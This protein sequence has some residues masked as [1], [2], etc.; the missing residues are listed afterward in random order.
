M[1]EKDLDTRLKECEEKL[2]R[3]DQM[4]SIGKVVWRLFL[5][6]GAAIVAVTEV[7]DRVQHSWGWWK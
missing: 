3:L 2:R 6:T 1:P 7:W 5:Y 4:E